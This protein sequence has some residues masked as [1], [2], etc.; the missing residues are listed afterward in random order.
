MRSPRLARMGRDVDRGVVALTLVTS[1]LWLSGCTPAAEDPDRGGSTGAAQ[2]LP[3]LTDCPDPT[4]QPATGEQTLPELSLPCLDGDGG[5]LTL[6]EAPGLALVVNLWATWCKPCRD[7]LP[8]F[9]RLY[10]ASDREELL[11]AGVVTRDGP[12]MAAEFVVDLDIEFPNGLD[13]NGDLY[14]DQGLRGLPGTFF[15]DADGAIVH[16]ELAPIT[17]YED[18]VAL[19]QQHLGVSV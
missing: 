8:L 4:G 5:E 7:E 17:S 9:S 6:G 11:V 10:A 16:A 15:V 14:V 12:G 18:L 3:D 19:V 1:V 2:E 13:E